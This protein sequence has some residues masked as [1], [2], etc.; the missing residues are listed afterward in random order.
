MTEFKSE[1]ERESAEAFTAESKEKQ[2]E[3]LN[4]APA[5]STRGVQRDR[6][7]QDQVERQLKDFDM[8]NQEATMTKHNR[9]TASYQLRGT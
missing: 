5:H 4:T 3:W 7:G 2:E 1:R 9:A 6:Y 8:V